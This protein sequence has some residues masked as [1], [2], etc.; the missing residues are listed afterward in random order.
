MTTTQKVEQILRDTPRTRD[1][2]KALFVY[3]MQASGMNL[4]LSQIEAFKAMPSLESV[5][6][7]RQKLQEQGK[8][9][10]SAT[11]KKERFHKSLVMSQ[12]APV[13]SPENIERTINVPLPWGE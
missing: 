3:F 11:V 8:Y 6:R 9:E 7:I 2:D 12:A 1:S 13:Y 10:A 5:R 4:S